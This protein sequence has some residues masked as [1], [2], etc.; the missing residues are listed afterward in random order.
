MVESAGQVTGN[1]T[2]TDASGADAITVTGTFVPPNAALTFAFVGFNPISFTA[3][4][5][6]D[7]QLTG[8]LNGSGYVNFAVTLYRTP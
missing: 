4:Q 5:T 1:G 2:F 7:H 6:N 3:T 8:T